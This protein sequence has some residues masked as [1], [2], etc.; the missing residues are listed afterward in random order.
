MVPDT[1]TEASW[2]K[3]AA[4]VTAIVRASPS[5]SAAAIETS[6]VV[7]SFM[8]LS[9]I[10]AKVGSSGTSS[11]VT[12]NEVSADPPLVSVTVRVMVALPGWFPDGVAVTVRALPTPPMAMP[13]TGSKVLLEDLAVTMRDPAGVSRSPTV[14]AMAAVDLPWGTD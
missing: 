11:K 13:E 4:L 10:G 12:T 8:D 14:K 7:S 6:R 1:T 2:E 3:E 5:G 9:R